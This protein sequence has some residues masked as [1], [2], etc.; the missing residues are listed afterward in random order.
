MTWMWGEDNRPAIP[1]KSKGSGIM[2]SDFVKEHDGHLLTSDQYEAAKR[3]NPNIKQSARV[4]LEYDAEREGYWTGDRFLEQIKTVCD[5]ASYKYPS[6]THTVAFK[7]AV[8]Q[9]MLN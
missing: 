6:Q 7:V 1:P 2:V 4:F 3:R 8:T 9:N 5:I